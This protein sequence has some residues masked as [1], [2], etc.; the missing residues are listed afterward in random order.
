MKACFKCKRLLLLGEFYRHHAMADGHLGKCKECARRDAF[1]RSKIKREHIA[2]YERRRSSDPNR[3]AK[4]SQY[5]RNARRRNA[6]KIR[7]RRE[8]Q[9]AIQ[10]GKLVKSPCVYCGLSTVEAHH[11]NYDEPLTVVWVCFKCH[12]EKFHGQT[13]NPPCEVTHGKE[14]TRPNATE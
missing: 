5:Q 8:V 4:T 9:L 10:S 3:K 14:K 6:K 1:L 13:T 12:R 7:A 11:A 2:E